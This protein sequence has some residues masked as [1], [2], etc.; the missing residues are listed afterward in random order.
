MGLL[1][2]TYSHL[3]QLSTAEELATVE[4]H[5]KVFGEDHP[6]TLW[7]MGELALIFQQQGQ[8][9]H[10][11]ELL[12]AVLEKRRKLLGDDHP[13]TRWTMDQLANLYQSIGKFQAAEELEGLTGDQ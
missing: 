8:L 2:S 12:V 4:K 7:I 6:E 5:Q 10:A 11:E 13:Q 1:A 3:G 9:E